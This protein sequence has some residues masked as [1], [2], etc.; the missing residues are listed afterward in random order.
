ML[1]HQTGESARG[2]VCL[3]R[4]LEALRRRSDQMST[5]IAIASI[6][7]ITGVPGRLEIAEAAAEAVLSRPSVRPLLTITAKAGLALPAAQRS[8]QSA[9]EE[10]YADLPM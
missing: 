9:T 4:L 10:H 5:S 3:E 2:E 8:D 1:E 7:R 6:A